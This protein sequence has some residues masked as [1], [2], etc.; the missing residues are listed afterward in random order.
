MLQYN[1]KNLIDDAGD[2]YNLLAWSKKIGEN[3]KSSNFNEVSQIFSSCAGAAMYKKSL[4][5]EIGYFDS[6][7]FAYTE[8][9]DLSLRAHINGY[10]NF[11]C[12]YAI[13][14]HIG[15]ATSGSR[16]N[17]FKVKLSAR[18]NIWVVYKNFPIPQKILN[19]IFLF[20]D[21]LLSI[22]FS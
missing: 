2:E 9:I 22:Y 8:D 19:F 13:V 17:E 7:F 1:N 4:L 3:Q 10:K 6:N 14:Y 5:D 12:P 15:S 16:Y 21:F 11:S 20:L 18:N